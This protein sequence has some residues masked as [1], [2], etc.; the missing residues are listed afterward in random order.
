M[1]ELTGDT[2]IRIRRS[3][4]EPRKRELTGDTRIRLSQ[5]KDLREWVEDRRKYKVGEISETTGLMKQRSKSGE[6]IWIDPQKGDK[7]DPNEKPG[8]WNVPRSLGAS[9]KQYKVTVNYNKGRGKESW[10]VSMKTKDNNPAWYLK[11]GSQ[12]KS[13]YTM[14]AGKDIDDIKRLIRV[15]KELYN[16]DSRVEDWKK[17]TGRAKVTNGKEEMTIIV[18]W[19]EC[20]NIGKMEFKEKPPRDLEWEE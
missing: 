20:A 2:I 8:S 13:V 6:I 10:K 15:G 18:H 12:I 7:A 16:K 11:E 9:A 19:Y 5:I 3:R 1:R 14:D 17:R 4:P